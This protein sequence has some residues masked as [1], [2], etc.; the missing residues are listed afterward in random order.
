VSSIR[1][2]DGSPSST[3]AA[4]APS[5]P[6]AES[7]GAPVLTPMPPLPPGPIALPS[8]QPAATSPPALVGRVPPQTTAAP[9][10]NL[11]AAMD[12]DAFTSRDLG[13][14]AVPPD[15]LAA[16]G[17]ASRVLI[18]GHIMP[19]GDDVGSALALARALRAL[20]KQVDVCIDDD[21]PG[22]FRAVDTDHELQRAAALQGGSWDLAVVVDPGSAERIRDA[23]KLL[24]SA[25]AVAVIDHHLNP[26]TPADYGRVAGPEFMT[27]LEPGF[28]AAAMMIG[29]ILSK[30]DPALSAAGADPEKLYLPALIGFCTDTGWGYYQG[31]DPE[32][33]RYFKFMLERG[34]TTLK[35]LQA[36]MDS[37]ELP[38][39]V[40]A[41]ATQTMTIQSSKLP[42]ALEAELLALDARGQGV[43][44]FSEKH[45][46]GAPGLAMVT[47]TAAY[48]DGL[49]RVGQLE[50]PTLVGIDVI[51]P[52]KYGHLR[53][54]QELGNPLA[55]LL[56]SNARGEVV[57]EL[58][59]VGDA[60]FRLA[61]SLGG[62]GHDQA[63]GATLE[64]A[65]LDVVR[66]RVLAWAK[67]DGITA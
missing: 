30:L 47:V 36:V 19:D 43:R 60:A 59:S 48:L 35:A 14:L 17:S 12:D 57:A 50:D 21:I 15:L 41:L 8:S 18:I 42:P 56:F 33:F 16:F 6:D 38:K 4:I 11:A 62:G 31:I 55:A 40:W 20:G 22:S 66:D 65:A 63:A 26:H 24:P 2:P 23:A 67:A 32:D 29:A 5:A 52:F 1:I 10:F 37:F 34:G 45:T 13:A 27:W 25:A 46:D 64:G 61:K 9:K 58:R 49:L 54:M 7:T 53:Q 3:V 39:R 51:A 28:P 44:T